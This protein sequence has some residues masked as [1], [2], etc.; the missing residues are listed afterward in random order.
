MFYNLF[1]CK[2]NTRI[3]YFNVTESDILSIIKSLDSTIAHG[4]EKLSIRMIKM[5]TESITLPLKII[6]HE[7]L[8]KKKFLE[9]W[10]LQQM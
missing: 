8:K 4:Y 7:P 3:N 5:S 9:I 2:S 6:F 1:P 10:K